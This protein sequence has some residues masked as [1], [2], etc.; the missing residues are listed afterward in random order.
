MPL[1][2]TNFN[3][4]AKSSRAGFMAIFCQRYLKLRWMGSCCMNWSPPEVLIKR[5]VQTVR[6]TSARHSMFRHPA[7]FYWRTLLAVSRNKA[8][9]NWHC[10]AGSMWQWV[11]KKLLRKLKHYQEDLVCSRAAKK[12]DLNQK[13]VWKCTEAFFAQQLIPIQ[14]D[15]VL[16]HTA[17]SHLDLV[18]VPYFHFQFTF[19]TLLSNYPCADAAEPCFLFPFPLMLL[20]PPSDIPLFFMMYRFYRLRVRML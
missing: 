6:R 7:R 4:L 8:Q 10:S 1:V 13:Q 19:S 20:Q 11:A 17:Y 14:M 2:Q 12:K 15:K 3:I 18:I 5:S 9:I 16:T